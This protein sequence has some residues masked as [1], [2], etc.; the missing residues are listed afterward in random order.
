MREL[1]NFGVYQPPGGQRRVVAVVN[2]DGYFLYD[3][4]YFTTLPPRFTVKADNS[5]L[6]WH[7]R[8]AG[9]GADDLLDTGETFDGPPNAGS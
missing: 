3:H 6:D 1:R 7:L 2:G 8:P 9:W 4:E 5:V